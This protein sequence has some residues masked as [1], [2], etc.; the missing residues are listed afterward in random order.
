MTAPDDTD[1]AALDRLLRGRPRRNRGTAS[2]TPFGDPRRRG[3]GAG[4]PHPPSAA[5]P[6]SRRALA[7]IGGWRGLAALA[8]CAALGFWLGIAGEV[9]LDGGTAWNGLDSAEST[10]DQVGAF[11]DLASTEG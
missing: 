11:F 9:T 2:R 1:Q 8:A 10:A 7:P 6:R 4:R 5:P 3:R